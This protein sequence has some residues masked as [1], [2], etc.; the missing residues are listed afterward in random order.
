MQIPG[1]T[2][3]TVG[4]SAKKADWKASDTILGFDQ[5]STKSSDQTPNLTCADSV[6]AEVTGGRVLRRSCEWH[7]VG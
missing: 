2:V 7:A 3:F 4:T 6:M 5:P 1:H